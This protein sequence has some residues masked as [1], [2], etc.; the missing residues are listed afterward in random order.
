M[1]ES[2]V[3]KS[4]PFRKSQILGI[5]E[6]LEAPKPLYKAPLL[7]ICVPF[8]ITFSC[9]VTNISAG[10]PIPGYNVLLLVGGGQRAGEPT[11]G[12]RAR[13]LPALLVDDVA[14]R[15]THAR[16]A[17][18]DTSATGRGVSPRALRDRFLLLA[19]VR[20]IRFK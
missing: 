15:A 4:K 11:V 3:A 16:A 5:L 7:T 12:R 14:R 2:G 18:V 17:F 1:F 20:Y 13:G 10:V 9:S 19:Q 8:R 6:N